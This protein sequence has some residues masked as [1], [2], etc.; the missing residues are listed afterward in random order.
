MNATGLGRLNTDIAATE[1]SFIARKSDMYGGSTITAGWCD[2]F[3]VKTKPLDKFPTLEEVIAQR[4][5]SG[6]SAKCHC[7]FDATQVCSKSGKEAEN[8]QF[9]W[10]YS[11]DGYLSKWKSFPPIAPANTPERCNTPSHTDNK[12]LHGVC[13]PGV[14]EALLPKLSQ[15]SVYTV[16]VRPVLLS[17]DGQRFAGP[18]SAHAVIE[19]ALPSTEGADTTTVPASTDSMPMPPVV[20]AVGATTVDLS[21]HGNS[22]RTKPGADKNPDYEIQYATDSR[23]SR[24]QTFRP[25]EDSLALI[26]DNSRGSATVNGLTEG[27]VDEADGFCNVTANHAGH[28]VLLTGLSPSTTY[29]V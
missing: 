23:F 24:W 8:L 2:N 13:E 4:D 27:V 18:W 5:P 19:P 17:A 21:C 28:F 20:L 22:P 10:Q 12:R 15:T 7:T 14:C 3:H 1:K 25:Q 6:T 11:S 29:L 9:E 26:D 16:R